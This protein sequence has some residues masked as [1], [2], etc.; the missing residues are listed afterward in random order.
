M[1]NL[2]LQVKMNFGM[3]KWI[4]EIDWTNGF[5]GLESILKSRQSILGVEMDC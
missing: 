1:E 4:A 2:I 5:D 3:L